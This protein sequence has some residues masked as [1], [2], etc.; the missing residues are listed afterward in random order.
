MIRLWDVRTGER[1]KY[2]EG[3]RDHIFSLAFSTDGFTIASGSWGRLRL[4]AVHTGEYQHI[5]AHGNWI[6]A[7]AFSPDGRTLAS[8]GSDKTVQLWDARTGEH[9]QILEGYTGSIFSHTGPVFSLAFSPDGGTL[10]SGSVDK[11]IRLWDTRTWKH[12]QLLEGHENSVSSLAFSPDGTTLASG[13]I[14]DTIRL[15]DARTGEY[16]QTLEGHTDR[17]LAVVFSPDGSTLASG[18]VDKTVRLW[19]AITG[20]HKQTL[21]GHTR[22]V[23]SV[24]YT[25]DGATLASGSS[26]ASVL[27]WKLTPSTNTVN[28][29]AE[30]VN[31]DGVVNP[32]DLAV[33]ASQFGQS[34]QDAADVNGDGIVNIL[35]LVLVAGAFGETAAAPAA[36]Q[37][38]LETLTATDV[39]RWLTNAKSLEINDVTIRKG[40]R[41]LEQLL[42]ALTEASTIPKETILLPNYP[43]PFNPETWIPYRLAEDANVTLTIY[44]SNGH[45]VRSFDAGYRTA[46]LYERRDKAIYWDGRNERGERVTSGVYFYH[47]T[48]ERYSAT[49]RMVILK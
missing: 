1:Q 7:L 27:L 43:N 41:V 48:T 12:K 21:E 31:Q 9:Q 10:A 42:A 20:E 24:A 5:E 4:W 49:K 47:L 14:D 30:D 13:S 28:L 3:H 34:S 46:G 15:W 11:T 8:G 29:F 6:N 44:D 26:D 23:R 32:L 36:R 25:S 39:Q 35:D 18:S 37:Q 22:W 38:V 33:V 16:Q 45:L 2:L 19:D 17:V 40:I